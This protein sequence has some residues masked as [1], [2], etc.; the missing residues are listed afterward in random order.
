[1][2]SKLL[3]L[4]TIF[5]TT[6]CNEF[7][8]VQRSEDFATDTKEINKLIC[9]APKA[10]ILNEEKGAVIN[11][12]KQ[13]RLTDILSNQIEKSA[14]RTDINLEIAQLAKDKNKVSFY[15]DLLKLKNEM[16]L[17]NNLQATQFNFKSKP[18]NNTIQEKVFFY[19]PSIKHEF[20]QFSEKYETP[21][22]SFIGLFK[23]DSDFI[24]YHVMVNTNTAQTVFRE[25]SRVGSRHIRNTTIAQLVHDSFTR[26]KKDLK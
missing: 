7:I 26:I 15:N 17:A 12:K 13:A 22:Y 24:F 6:A 21:Y 2:N 16:L 10:R 25:I 9:V 23:Q 1:L 19:P 11:L 20:S 8:V 4:F 3:L 5:I 18:N 14:K